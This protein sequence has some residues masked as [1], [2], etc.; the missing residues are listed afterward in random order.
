MKIYIASK[1]EH[2]NMWSKL[3][4]IGFDIIP[5]CCDNNK[6]REYT[7]VQYKLEM[8]KADV[9]ILYV[10]KDETLRDICIEGSIALTSGKPIY[11]VLDYDFSNIN[12]KDNIN[13]FHMFRKYRHIKGIVFKEFKDINEALIDIHNTNTTPTTEK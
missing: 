1:S 12:Y 3:R 11:L 13:A 6:D 8:K 2:A 4:D 7:L 5:A 10:E 9:I